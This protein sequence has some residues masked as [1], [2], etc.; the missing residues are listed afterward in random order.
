[1]DEF[2]SSMDAF[3]EA[4]IEIKG[5]CLTFVTVAGGYRGKVRKIIDRRPESLGLLI[6]VVDVH[7]TSGAGKDF[8]AVPLSQ[9]VAVYHNAQK[10]R[11]E[12][13]KGV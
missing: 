10:H 13:S 1:M 3:K 4:G 8:V 11:Y 5:A 6:E 9:I 12:R 2:H 7:D